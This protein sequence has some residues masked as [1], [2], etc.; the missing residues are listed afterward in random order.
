MNTQMGTSLRRISGIGLRSVVASVLI[1]LGTAVTYA[2]SVIDWNVIALKTTAAAPFNPPLESRNLAI[3]HA[4]MFDAVNSIVSEFEHYAVQQ[5]APEDASPEAA[6]AAA[7]HFALVQLYPAQQAGLDSAY[8]A[9]LLK[10]PDGPAKNDG[11]AMGESV[12]AKI[13]AM[14][15][16]DGAAAA[17]NAGYTP[18]SQPGDWIP[19]PPKFLSAWKKY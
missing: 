13:L 1:L 18:G 15:A 4:A 11:I 16:D 7:A 12:A 8:A 19:T 10:I 17:I 3:V 2:D 5:D 9:S 14:R 6:A